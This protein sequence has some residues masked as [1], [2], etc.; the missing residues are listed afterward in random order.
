M[1]SALIYLGYNL[2]STLDDTWLKP[3]LD[4]GN[5]VDIEGKWT[6]HSIETHRLDLTG[7][8]NPNQARILINN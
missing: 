7:K 5:I 8:S 6:V 3:I 1:T 4:M 2:L